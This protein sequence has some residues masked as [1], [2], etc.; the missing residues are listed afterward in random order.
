MFQTKEIKFYDDLT[1]AEIQLLRNG[2][3]EKKFEKGKLIHN[4]VEPCRGVII[5]REG[6]LRTYMLSEEGKEIT[7][8]YLEKGEICILS[9]SCVLSTISFEVHIEA[10]EDTEVLQI[11]ASCFNQIMKSNLKVEN[12]AL[13]LATEKFSDV[14][15]TMQQILFFSM[16]KRLSM[17]LY[18]EAVK[19]SDNVLCVTH[20][21]IAKSLGTAREVVTRLLK[22]FTLDNIVELTRGKIT[23][24]D[25]NKLLSNF[26]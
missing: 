15:W 9:A 11:S 1:D 13:R 14:M 23:I 6:K 7:L 24:L 26:S 16:D 12:F 8:Y 19:I 20:E 4:S 18:E 25:K 17:Y 22:Q 21:Q 2:T 3:F 10:A 5:V